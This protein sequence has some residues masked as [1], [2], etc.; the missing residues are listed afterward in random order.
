MK[1]PHQM[2]DSSVA[3]RHSLPLCW[4]I[5]NNNANAMMGK[6][7]SKGNLQQMDSMVAIAELLMP[8][9]RFTETDA[10]EV[11]S[12]RAGSPARRGI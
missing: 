9:E 7:S 11:S 12:D 4:E 5:R 2:A 8:G 1:T 6:P 3:H 10:V